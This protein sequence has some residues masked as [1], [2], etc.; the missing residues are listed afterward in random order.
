MVQYDCLETLGKHTMIAR[1]TTAAIGIPLLVLVI[2][3]GGPWF[4]LVVAIVAAIG[5]AE[6]CRMA[7]NQGISTSMPAAIIWAVSLVV[8]AYVLTN[9]AP[10]FVPAGIVITSS[11]ALLILLVTTRR[12]IWL[13]VWGATIAAALY[14][15]L[16]LAHAP[17]LREID[18]GLEWVFFLFIVTFSTDT[19]A[20]FVGKAIGKRSLAPTISPKKTWEGAIG[21]F[22]AA[23]VAATVAAAVLN[24]DAEMV[25]VVVLGALMGIVGQ[26]GDLVESK[27]KRLANIKDSGW[28][29]PGHG[30]VLDRLDSIVFNLVLVY[31]FIIWGVQ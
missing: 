23:I 6:V 27:L 21:G 10:D 4:G 26:A 28:L 15:A 18:P 25:A 29:I 11:V 24:L 5:T 12:S 8:A 22:V 9:D 14:P 31:Y 13:P 20:F 1:L 17:L 7:K 3:A 16:L 30:G 2:W 19:A